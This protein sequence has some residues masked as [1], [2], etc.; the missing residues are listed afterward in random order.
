MGQ[1][2]SPSPRG[3][4]VEPPKSPQLT[5]IGAGHVF[6]IAPAIRDA[7]VALR[8]QVVFLELDR[9][10]FQA[11][12][13][14]SQGHTPD[15]AGGFVQK[16]L[17]KFQEGVA[18]MYGAEVGEEMLAGADGAKAIGARIALVDDDASSI[19]QQ[20]RKAMTVGE[21][22]RF[23]GLLVQ[24]LAKSALPSVRRNAA[25]KVEDELREYQEN[26]EKLLAEL[27]GKFPS[28]HRVVIE[29]RNQ[30]MADRI[31]AIVAQ[32]AS[33]VAI[34]GDG[35]VG[36]MAALLG[37]LNPTV[38]RLDDVREGRLPRPNVATGTHEKVGFGWTFQ[39]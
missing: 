20:A 35:H 15:V 11:L 38:Y 34:L 31:R 32:G 30:R 28:I 17:A 33:G 24:G 18:G 37:D 16:Q 19:I 26:P 25:K 6:K 5:L 12:V 36:G 21:R 14:K 39:L 10:R 29:D 13:A 3:P 2:K 23:M 22:L 1:L 4:R 27:K 8:P 7:V 9:G